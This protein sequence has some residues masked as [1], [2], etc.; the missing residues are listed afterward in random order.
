M[1]DKLHGHVETDKNGYPSGKV[2]ETLEAGTRYHVIVSVDGST[3]EV[4]QGFLIQPK[5]WLR[6]LEIWIEAKLHNGW[7]H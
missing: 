2:V 3:Y 6:R 7:H 5:S 4:A 1:L